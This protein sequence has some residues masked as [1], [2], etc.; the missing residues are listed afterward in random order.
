MPTFPAWAY[1]EAIEVP[2]VV[3]PLESTDL[4]ALPLNLIIS[5]GLES[6]WTAAP[7]SLREALANR[8]FSFMRT[9][10]PSARLGD[11]Y[12][13]LQEER[14]PIVLT[15]DALFFLA[16]VALDRAFAEVDAYV[17]APL[18]STLLH[19]LDLRLASEARG[20]VADLA[21][22]YAMAQSV[23]AVGLALVEPSYVPPP[24]IA[25]AV[26]A[27]R[28]HVLSHA[29]IA[30]SPVF[31]APLDYSA[32]A[33]R[34]TADT[35][36]VHAGWFRAVSWLENASFV[37][38]G[39][40]ERNWHG[41]VD[42]AAARVQTRAAL[43]LARAL[44]DGVDAV[45]GRA[46]ERVEQTSELTIG[47]AVDVSPRDL[48][49]A[50]AR[51]EL[52]LRSVDWMRNVVRVDRVR[53]G[54]SRGRKSPTFKLLGPR[55]TP[56][57]EV[58]QSLVF[59]VVGVRQSADGP[60]LGAARAFPSALDIAAWLGSGE[61]RAVLHEAGDDAYEGYDETLE[62]LMRGR[63][64][65]V[66]PAAPG[67]HR[68]PYLSLIDAIETWLAPSAGDAVQPGTSTVE[69]RKRKAGV[70]LTAWTELRHDAT[71]L[72]RIASGDVIARVAAFTP[73]SLTVFVE[74]H[75]EAIAE[76]EGAIRQ[77]A[78]ALTAEGAL[79]SGSQAERVLD[80]VDDLLWTALGGAVYETADEPFPPQL[81]AAL[82]AVPARIRALEAAIGRSGAADV[83]LVADV[84]VGAASSGRLEEATGPVEDAWM[85]MREPRTHRLWVAMGAWIPQDEL[86]QPAGRGLSDA[87]WRA[88]LTVE[89]SPPGSVLER[90]YATD[91]G[92]AVQAAA[93]SPDTPSSR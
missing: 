87:A 78:R 90:G 69:W 46:W 28:T 9:S 39:A 57:S 34:G 5:E 71:T 25:Q 14:I 10:A 31:G 72:T 38:E 36:E 67:R 30:T 80:D 56:D 52:D 3:A 89:G 43:L 88:R 92:A 64:S 42:V 79:R 37:L 62:R 58:L 22:A 65:V 15:M 73:S 75:A 40:G 55:R 27:E 6:R 20:A 16:H 45:A 35:D 11:F 17:I 50:V 83:R 48:A 4:S 60:S 59:P 84:H 19:R 2:L 24:A 63:P 44:D 8:G 91:P 61:A 68:T 49:G 70:A 81:A 12:V 74:P 13:A 41:R 1:W 26:A 51:A 33:V 7:A 32:M 82:W 77:A 18:L 54:V 47:D 85:A 29:G 66:S 23:V 93:G 86:V 21:S 53:H 76:L